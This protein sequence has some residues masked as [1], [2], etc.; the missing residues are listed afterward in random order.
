MTVITTAGGR[1]GG[2]ARVVGAGLLGAIAS[3]V[4][5]FP[6]ASAAPDCNQT[7]GN[8]INSY[9]ERHPDLHRQLQQESEREGDGGNVITYLNKHPDV[10]Q[11]LIDL[12]QQCVP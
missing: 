2:A 3:M 4:I 12:S 8:S 11:H 7:V 1:R 5:A 6:V 9:L 10:R